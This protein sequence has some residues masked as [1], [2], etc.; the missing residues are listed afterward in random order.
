M[1][2]YW[3]P[4][5]E[6]NY[7]MKLVATLFIALIFSLFQ[8]H[9]QEQ[10]GLRTGNFAGINGWALNPSAHTTT[11]FNWEL[12]LVEGAFFFDNNY[13][14]LSKTGLSHLVANRDNI[15]FAFGPD[16]DKET[17]PP[18]GSVVLD[19]YTDARKRYAQGLTS[20][21]GPSLFV[22]IGKNHAIGAFVRG[23]A[24]ASARGLVNDFSY[25]DYFDRPF[26]VPFEVTPFAVNMATWSEWGLNYLFRT[27]TATGTIGIGFNAR[28]LQ[29]YEGIYLHS[30]RAFPLAKLPGDSLS[31]GPIEFEYGHTR[32][33]LSTN[34]IRLSPNGGGVAFDIGFTYVVGEETDYSWRIGVSVLD[35]GRLQ[36]NRNARLHRADPDATSVIGFENYN[37]FILPD[38]YENMLARF[39]NDVLGNPDAS[40]VGDRFAMWLPAAISFQLDRNLG[41][42]F[43]LNAVVVQGIP[44]GGAAMWRGGLVSLTPR[45]EKRWIELA[46]P[47]SLFHGN[48]LQ[49]GVAGRVGGLTIGSDR[50]GSVLGRSNWSGSD[51]YAALKIQP[52]KIQT[53]SKKSRRGRGGNGDVKC[54]QF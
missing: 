5:N 11:P 51:V 8:L 15:E 2:T 52:F 37:D 27:E 1:K 36:F 33:N 3:S 24:F 38:D 54:Y 35:I 9:A 31:G 43:Y 17:P 7:L 42:G 40:L 28:L 20:V 18:P 10:I 45:F 39:S 13:A 23:R 32:S 25:Y 14:F 44:M 53:A 46:V 48:R 30:Q 29:A 16:F 26:E 12:N 21:T 6:S 50:I 49:V 4:K 34:D 47:V 41:A 22:R 19:F